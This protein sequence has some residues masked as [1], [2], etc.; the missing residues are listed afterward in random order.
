[1]EQI[2]KWKSDCKEHAQLVTVDAYAMALWLIAKGWY[3]CGTALHPENGSVLFLF[4]FD[5]CD[6]TNAYYEAK[7]VLNKA[8][9]LARLGGAR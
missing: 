4:P 3:V 7:H 1:M 8:Q 2:Q 9:R 6:D 5:C